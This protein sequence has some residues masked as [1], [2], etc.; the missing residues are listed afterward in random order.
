MKILFDTGA[1]GFLLYS[2]QD[3]NRL[4]DISDIKETNHA[5]GIVS[6]G[7]AG[8]GSPVEIKN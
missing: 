4:A 6:A 7:L 3:Y 1:E 5:H 8:L 2:I